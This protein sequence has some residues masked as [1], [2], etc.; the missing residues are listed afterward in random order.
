MS[1]AC[2][3]PADA[4]SFEH[5]NVTERSAERLLVRAA[6]MRLIRNALVAGIVVRSKSPADSPKQQG[7][8]AH[9]AAVQQQDGLV[10]NAQAKQQQQHPTA[11]H[12]APQQPLSQQQ[13]H[14]D[15]PKLQRQPAKARQR[16]VAASAARRALLLEQLALARVQARSKIVRLPLRLSIEGRAKS[17][18]YLTVPVDMDGE[19]CSVFFLIASA[20]P[21]T[22]W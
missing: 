10:S 1:C 18:R 20:C 19:H 7:A 14:L 4:A 8:H 21:G 13:Q 16:R 2:L 22:G 17:R 6:D 5:P 3:H 11:Q 12:P 15:R 9:Q